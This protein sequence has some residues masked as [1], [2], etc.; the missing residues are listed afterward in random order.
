MKL[1]FKPGACS[2]SPHIIAR[3]AGLPI[4]LD[5]V[6]TKAG[7]TKSGADFHQINPKGYVPTLQLD[8]GDVLTEAAVIAQYLADQ[9]PEA[10]LLP[11]AGT[12]ERYHAQEW[13]NY[14]ATELHKGI[15]AL[16][17]PKTSDEQKALQREQ[18]QSRLAY[19][20]GKLEGRDYL[21][22]DR[23]TAP[24]AYLYTV[25]GWTDH[26]GVDLS[27]YPNL[28]AYRKRVGERP[29]VQAARKAEGLPV[30]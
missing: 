27:P 21:A 18:L 8:D 4:E 3:E 10:Q 13:F 24:D 16:F 28:V 12:R 22:G 9:K 14:I 19:A 17:N 20:N 25:L 26:V 5:Q 6:D 15:G 1:Y 2:L 23:F 30:R 7:R 11:P 29:A